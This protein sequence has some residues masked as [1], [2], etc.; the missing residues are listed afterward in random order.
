MKVR[1]SRMVKSGNMNSEVLM[2]VTKNGFGYVLSA[3]IVYNKE[4][5]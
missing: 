3:K 1:P 4:L 5:C 2:Y